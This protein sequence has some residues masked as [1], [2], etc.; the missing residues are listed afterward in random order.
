VKQNI[1]PDNYN[2]VRAVNEAA[3]GF[4]TGDGLLGWLWARGPQKI[5]NQLNKRIRQGSLRVH[6]PDGQLIEIGGHAPGPHGEVILKNWRPAR[7]LV[8]GGHTAF[9]T[10]YIDGDWDSPDMASLFEVFSLNRNVLSNTIRGAFLSRILNGLK[11]AVRANT[12]EGSKKNIQFHYDLGNAFYAQW[13][14]P[15]MTYSSAIF[16]DGD[17]CLES[18]QTRKYR[19]LLDMLDAKPG[20]RVLEIGSGWGGFAELAARERGLHV[21]GVTLS[22]EQLAY[23][24]NRIAKAGLSAQAQFHLTDYR[25]IDPARHGGLFD[26]VVSIEMFEAV[27]EQYWQTYMDKVRDVLRPGGRIA[28]QIITI[29]DAIFEA[30]RKGADFIQTYIFPGGMLPSVGRLKTAVQ[31]A[32]LDWARHDSFGPHY[33]RTLRLWLESFEKTLADGK[34]PAGFDEKFQRIWRYYLTYCEGGF[35]GGGIDVQQVA[36]VKPE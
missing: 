29:D 26:H 10:S 9:A 19:R 21:T 35:R 16:A 13:L 20:E 8:I 1:P 14:D 6:T 11:H 36:L 18:A 5:V 7:R 27:G 31:T 17:N 32:G 4:V 15:S 12:Q 28:L 2:R 3:T 30:Y 23:A 22:E 34:L 25:D 24:Q 33:A